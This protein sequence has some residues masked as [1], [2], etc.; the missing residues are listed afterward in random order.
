MKANH[1]YL[2][3]APYIHFQSKHI[4]L[5]QT[6]YTPS[7]L[8]EDNWTIT[9]LDIITPLAWINHSKQVDCQQLL[10]W[11]SLSPCNKLL[12]QYWE[13]DIRVEILPLNSAI[14]L[15]KLFIGEKSPYQLII[16]AESYAY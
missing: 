9:P 2:P 13:K 4:R 12:D 14:Q 15:T 1:H 6:M 11:P 16:F 10:C 8:I 5:N 7:I 3:Q